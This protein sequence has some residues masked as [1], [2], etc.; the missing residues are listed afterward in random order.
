M[1][2]T[3]Y[4]ACIIKYEGP[5]LDRLDLEIAMQGII[6]HLSKPHKGKENVFHTFEC[7][8]L[9]VEAICD[10]NL[11]YKG[12]YFN[13]KEILKGFDWLYEKGLKDVESC[14]YEAKSVEWFI[15]KGNYIRL[16]IVK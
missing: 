9:V 1:V 6:K 14:L 8:E 10:C 7:E 12:L 4:L 2:V 16:Y 5:E 15:H 3:R 13:T 11:I